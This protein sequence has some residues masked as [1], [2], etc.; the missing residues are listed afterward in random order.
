VPLDITV[1][2]RPLEEPAK[3]GAPTPAPVAEALPAFT[4]PVIGVPAG[5]TPPPPQSSGFV[6]PPPSPGDAAA[7]PPLD[8]T[9]PSPAA[10]T[11]E[12]A[13]TAT[14]GQWAYRQ[15]GTV[16]RGG[17]AAAPLEPA[18]S[19]AVS[20]ARETAQ[21][22]FTF[23]ETGVALGFPSSSAVYTATNSTA[24]PNTPLVS[25]MSRLALA[26]L[27]IPVNGGALVFQ[28]A[29]AL[30]LL[31]TPAARASQYQPDPNN[32]ATPTTTGS[33]KDSQTDPVTGTAMSIDASDLGR[34]RI[35]ACGTPVDAW[36]VQATITVVG[37][38]V[39]S[40]SGTPVP[41]ST[42]LTMNVTYAVATGLGGQIVQWTEKTSGTLAA[43]PFSLDGDATLAAPAPAAPR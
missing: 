23:H 29:T 14:N 6:L 39:T 37:T 12:V 32:P 26:G 25:P 13:T 27:S 7:C 10:A 9:R 28:P 21:G 8:P 1:G 33:W 43:A 22:N 30:T 19:R 5:A 38:Q 20:D 40:A 35:N 41:S 34:I 4:V 3:P 24:T 15:T 18:A 31:S 42:N 2:N 16:S 17:A 11:P 36:Q